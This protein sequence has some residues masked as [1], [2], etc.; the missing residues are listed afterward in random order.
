MRILLVSDYADT[1]FG[2]VGRELGRG[3]LGRGHDVRL[4]AINYRGLDGELGALMR[5]VLEPGFRERAR[6][7]FDVLAGDPL[8]E[9]MLPAATAINGHA[10]GHGHKLYGP[11]IHG[12][13][14]RGWHADAAIVVSD[15]YAALLRLLEGG[16]PHGCGS[17][18]GVPVYN[19]V[20]IEGTGI[21]PAWAMIYR[22]FRPVAMTAFGAAELERLTGAPV[23]LISHG[24]S[25]AFHPVGFDRPG[26]YRGRSIAT[27]DAAKAA[28]GLAGRTVVLRVD[29]HIYRKNYAAFF[30]VMRPVLAAHPELVCVIHCRPQDEYGNLYDLLAR[31]PGAVNTKP[32][33]IYGWTHPQYVLT[34]A[35]DTYSGLADAELNTLYNAADLLVS[36][37]MAEGFGLTHAEALAAGVPVV[38]TDYSAMPEV[39]GPG[40]VLV[41]PVAYMTN[42]YAHEWALVD[43]AAMSAAVERLVAKPA[44]RRALGEAGRAHVARFS[45]P[46]AVEQ[47][48]RL[49][50]GTP[51]AVAA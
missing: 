10:D 4:I 2:R 29:R 3:L 15:A 5:H 35:H 1:G 33:S 14:W 23:P 42:Q 18:A 48:E 34:N 46:H 7:R 27:K 47:F 16:A 9:R 31:E 26:S 13:V 38:T 19:Y 22:H 50:A 6:D 43:E 32:D 37:T 51:A 21:T 44:L 41:P 49:L 36:P 40:G 12:A 30:R 17:C 24:V 39:V 25:D 11:A 28:F 20:P 8:F 45:W